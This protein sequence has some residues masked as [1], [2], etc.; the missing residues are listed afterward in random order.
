METVRK[1]H[2]RGLKELI[3]AFMARSWG[4]EGKRNF[5]TSVVLP[6]RCFVEE[7]RSPSVRMGA[8][9]DEE[10]GQCLPW[11]GER[12]HQEKEMGIETW[13]S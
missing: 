7:M 8:C 3:D 1:G 11:W 12:C 5:L 2:S 13:G 4:R 9:H 10:R 6:V